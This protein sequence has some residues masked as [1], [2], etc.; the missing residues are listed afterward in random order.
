M[1][2][3]H[4][5]IGGKTFEEVLGVRGLKKA[6]RKKWEKHVDAAVERFVSALLVD[7][8]VLGG[9]NA[10]KLTKLPQGCRIGDNANAFIG[11]FRMWEEAKTRFSEV[12]KR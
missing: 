1:E 11:G 8:V 2:I 7:D 5:G 3:G 4:L 10:K 6:G 9:G 12:P